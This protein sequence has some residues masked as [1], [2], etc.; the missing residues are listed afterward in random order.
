MDDKQLVQVPVEVLGFQPMGDKSW[1]MKFGTQ[2]LNAHDIQILADNFQGMGWL[3]F[4]PNE[5]SLKDVPDGPADPGTKTRSQRLR[6]VLYREWEAKGRQGDFE[7]YY[8]IKMDRLIDLV[9]ERIGS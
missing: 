9:K 5:L 6:A 2:E 3:I 8:N 4:S 1:R 7:T